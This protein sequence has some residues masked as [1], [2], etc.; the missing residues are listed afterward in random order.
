MAEQQEGVRAEARIV[1]VVGINTCINNFDNF[2]WKE[3]PW[4]AYREIQQACGEVV[5]EGDN[6][7]GKMDCSQYLEATD[8]SHY[9]KPCVI[10]LQG[11]TLT[12]NEGELE[13]LRVS[14]TRVL[15]A[16]TV[17]RDPCRVVLVVST[18][19]HAFKLPHDATTAAFVLTVS[20]LVK[21]GQ[22]LDFLYT[23]NPSLKEASSSAKS[24]SPPVKPLRAAQ[25]KLS[26]EVSARSPEEEPPVLTRKQSLAMRFTVTDSEGS[27]TPKMVDDQSD[28]ANPIIVSPNSSGHYPLR[29]Q[30]SANRAQD[31][32]SGYYDELP[33]GPPRKVEELESTEDTEGK[34]AHANCDK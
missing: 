4:A 8:V 13:V 25:R 6:L 10:T 23:Q 7:P 16:V 31:C 34:E 11:N 2:I 26:Q 32:N 19:R 20:S 15:L 14:V 29:G 1:G 28:G 33:S 17:P 27:T 9:G 5:S 3:I 24:A 22:I 30:L 18:E 12:L 21:L